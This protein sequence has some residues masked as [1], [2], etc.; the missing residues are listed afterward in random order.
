MPLDIH[1]A[2]EFTSVCINTT[3][4]LHWLLSKCL[5][6]GVVV[7]RG[8]VDHVTDAASLHTVGQSHLVVNCTGL[9]AR[10]LGGVEDKSVVPARGQIMLVRNHPDIMTT[11][12]SL[13][14]AQPGDMAYMMCRPGGGG[15]ILGGCYQVDNWNDSPD[16]KLAERIMKRCVELYPELA[17]SVDDLSV[18]RQGVGFRPLRP[19]G[20]RLETEHIRGIPVVH[21]YGHGGWGYQSSYGCAKT[22]VSLVEQEVGLTAKL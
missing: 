13:V 10:N 21:N 17:K 7:K 3:I 8:V 2:F 6:N 9:M 19:Q 16:H 4:Y 12:S 18:I 20:V 5:R 14:A 22:V 11:A 15:T 1:T